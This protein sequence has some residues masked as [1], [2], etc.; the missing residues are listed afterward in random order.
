MRTTLVGACSCY[1]LPVPT[2]PP[3]CI[4]WWN[5]SDLHP[6]ATYIAMALLLDLPDEL[7]LHVT[8]DVSPDDLDCFLATH[9]MIRRTGSDRLQIHKKLKEHFSLLRSTKMSPS[10]AKDGLVSLA[11]FT[12]CGKIPLLRTIS[13]V[14]I[15]TE[16]L[17]PAI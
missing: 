12:G 3:S 13:S 9:C 6:V 1:R 15:G 10:L 11:Y 2:V 7:L 16:P 14:L 17:M 8:G 5:I 4:G